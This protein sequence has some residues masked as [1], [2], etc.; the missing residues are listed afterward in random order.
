[1]AF[2]YQLDLC[3][4]KMIP[5]WNTIRTWDKSKAMRVCTEMDQITG[6][7][8]NNLCIP[9]LV[10]WDSAGCEVIRY[11]INSS[12]IIAEIENNGFFFN[13]KDNSL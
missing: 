2:L 6:T 4:L 11:T 9:I 13:L 3:A 10:K 1:M 5:I 7:D 8:L 12:I